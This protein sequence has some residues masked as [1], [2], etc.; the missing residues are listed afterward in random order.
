MAGSGPFGGDPLGYGNTWLSY[1]SGTG[2]QG[3]KNVGQSVELGHQNDI[4]IEGK[5]FVNP[6]T[7]VSAA[8]PSGGNTA[9]FAAL[10]GGGETQKPGDTTAGVGVFGQSVA[11]DGILGKVLT[12]GIGVAGSCNTGCGVFGQSL[13]GSGVVGFATNTGGWGFWGGELSHTFQNAGVLGQSGRGVGV[14]GHGGV[15]TGIGLN[16]GVPTDGYVFDD[17]SGKPKLVAQ[18]PDGTPLLPS[19]PG[20]CFS[21]GLLKTVDDPLIPEGLLVSRS[22]QPQLRLVPSQPDNHKLPAIGT[23]G[24]FFLGIPFRGE[25]SLF[26]CLK[27]NP[28]TKKP[29]WTQVMLGADA[30]GDSLF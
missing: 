14:R 29:V 22:S 18:P 12:N 20:G 15:L 23:I 5:F 19:A 3:G 1:G 30:D 26:L 6:A 24:D 11:G 13:F 2:L 17:T 28:E 9:V 25:P 10:N 8:S 4:G 27:I 21:S 7:I 16:S